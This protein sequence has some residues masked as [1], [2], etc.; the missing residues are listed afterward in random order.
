M[1]HIR[2]KKALHGCFL[3]PLPAGPIRLNVPLGSSALVAQEGS[4]PMESL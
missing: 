3:Q 1:L 2:S 4:L